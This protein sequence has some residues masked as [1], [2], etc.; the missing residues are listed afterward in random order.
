MIFDGFLKIQQSHS[1]REIE[2]FP[3]ITDQRRERRRLKGEGAI[4]K[5]IPFFVFERSL[6]RARRAEKWK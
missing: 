4:E 1:Q 6:N 3:I 2:S 5:S